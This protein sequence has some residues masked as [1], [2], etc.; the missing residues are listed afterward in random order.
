MTFIFANFFLPRVSARLKLVYNNISAKLSNLM[1]VGNSP[2]FECTDEVCS[3]TLHN[4]SVKSRKLLTTTTC[5][6]C[7]GLTIVR[8]QLPKLTCMFFTVSEDWSDHLRFGWLQTP[9][10]WRYNS[11][12]GR[13]TP[14]LG[15]A[16]PNPQKSGKSQGRLAST[17]CHIGMCWVILIT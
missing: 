6:C 14:S 16:W 17:T 11:S 1:Y 10:S 4:K 15:R 13:T 2:R 8:I 3:F 9:Q 7:I 12:T 5:R